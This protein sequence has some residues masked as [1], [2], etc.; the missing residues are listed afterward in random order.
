M[1][2][3]DQKLDSP[4]GEFVWRSVRYA[5]AVAAGYFCGLSIGSAAKGPAF[6]LVAGFGLVG[7][8]WVFRAGKK[9]VQHA[10]ADAVASAR[11]SSTAAASA[12]ST[13]TVQVGNSNYGADSGAQ[14]SA[15]GVPEGRA[16][17]PSSRVGALPPAQVSPGYWDSDINADEPVE[18]RYV[19]E[20][21]DDDY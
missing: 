1:K 13:T 21:A 10:A 8:F 6:W 3:P 18:A 12:V 11:A 20:W 9:S 19:I 15:S 5:C 17:L 2:T 14:S 4:A 16:A 7:I